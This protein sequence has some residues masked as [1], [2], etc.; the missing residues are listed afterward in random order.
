M[1][2]TATEVTGR[3]LKRRV[4]DLTK[5][6]VGLPADTPAEL[7]KRATRMR[8]LIERLA[9]GVFRLVVMGEVK[10]GK[11]TFINALLGVPDILPTDSDVATSTV[12][13]IIYGPELAYTVYF[14][15][16]P[17]RPD[18]VPE[19]LPLPVSMERRKQYGIP[20]AAASAEEQLPYFGTE[21]GNPA[22]E[23]GVDFIA[24]EVPNPLLREGLTIVDTPGVGGL[25]KAHRDITFRYAPNAD[26]VM[27]VV[28]SVESVVGADEVRFLQDLKEV[29][30]HIFF[31]Q[32]KIDNADET[33]WQGWRARNLSIL[34]EELALPKEQIPYFP[35]SSTLK[36]RADEHHSGPDLSDSGFL[37]VTQFIQ[38]VLLPRKDHILAVQSARAVYEDMAREARLVA[39][40]LA[41][42][43]ETSQEKLAALKVQLTEAQTAQRE[44]EGGPWKKRVREFHDEVARLKRDANGRIQDTFATDS[45]GYRSAMARVRDRCS[46]AEAVYECAPAIL[47]DYAAACSHNGRK[48]VDG[49]N[50][51]YQAAFARTVSKGIAELR[52]T[53]VPDVTIGAASARSDEAGRLDAIRAG[54][55][56]FSMFG[57]LTGG[58]SYGVGYA[59]GAAVA[60][61]LI[62]NPV[63]WAIAAGAGVTALATTIWSAVK[64]YRGVRE[65]Q[66]SAAIANLER[67]MHEVAQRAFRATQRAFQ[68]VAAEL[69]A[70]ARDGFDEFV[71]STRT[72]LSRR[73]SEVSAT[74]ARTADESRVAVEGLTDR[75][76]KLSE[77]VRDITSVGNTAKAA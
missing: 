67:A 69:D 33:Q 16:P 39:D 36:Q 63:G 28:D 52:D 34:S 2:T 18:E 50:R 51:D 74:Q 56:N 38:T 64:G 17:D 1:E 12:Y 15:P 9:S 43:K 13:K 68:E 60:L 24:A 59:A 42:A 7:E 66:M 58:A 71:E 14:L 20:E 53:V 35:V 40:R 19:P 41:I 26:A 73:I 75:L 62:S 61:G 31:V 30:K 76:K 49:F 57:G 65:R 27:F 21:A 37:A 23:K 46:T 3:D 8:P 32:T 45:D 4:I 47:G 72:E 48:I 29:T 11:S 5:K 6:Y 77:L 10:K 25:F 22:N 70:H 44:W 54:F 55:M